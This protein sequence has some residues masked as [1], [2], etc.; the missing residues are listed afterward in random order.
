MTLGPASPPS[1]AVL[2]HPDQASG[3]VVVIAASVADTAPVADAPQRLAPVPLASARLVDEQ[4]VSGA[5]NPVLTV[6]GDPLGADRLWQPFRLGDEAPVRIVVGL[7]RVA[8]AAHHAA[9][10]GL[11]LLGLL[12]LAVGGPAQPPAPAAGTPAPGPRS[13]GLAGPAVATLRRLLAPADRVAP[14]PTRPGGE[15]R[16]W[17]PARITGAQATARLVE[18]AALAMGEHNRTHARRWR[19]IGVSIGVGGA[20]DWGNTAS[21]R[22]VDVGPDDD[23]RTAVSSA[24]AHGDVPAELRWPPRLLRRSGPVTRR[25]GDSLLVSNLGRHDLPGLA[26]VVFFPVARG[27]SAVAIGA[28]AG[29]DGLGTVSLRARDL[30]RADASALLDGCLQHL[31]P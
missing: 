26:D 29:R 25:L 20:G 16:V 30:T 17:R 19:R 2:R 8:L 6:E 15:S 27:R 14:S 13:T 11:S 24:L 12:H 3:W 10:D 7:N 5:P 18:A 1:L 4:W 9:F 21:Y 23:L 31:A 28:V 22:R